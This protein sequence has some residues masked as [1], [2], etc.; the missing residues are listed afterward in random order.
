MKVSLAA[1]TLSCSVA[2]AIEEKPVK[3]RH[4]IKKAFQIPVRKM[5][6][7]LCM[8]IW[9]FK[10]IVNSF[11]LFCLYLWVHC[12]KTHGQTVLFRVQKMPGAS[13]YTAANQ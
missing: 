9:H 12:V 5:R 6:K 8:N 10:N 1:Q 11:K 2:D 13:A 3:N 7:T 4:K